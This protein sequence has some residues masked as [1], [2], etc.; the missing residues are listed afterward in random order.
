MRQQSFVVKQAWFQ[1]ALFENDFV[2]THFGN[3][4]ILRWSEDQGVLA[5]CTRWTRIP[6][7]AVNTRHKSNAQNE[8][9]AADA[10]GAPA[11]GRLQAV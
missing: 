7:E 11:L 5:L 4:I 10:Y 2:W 9:P 8:V 1:A 3:L 6:A